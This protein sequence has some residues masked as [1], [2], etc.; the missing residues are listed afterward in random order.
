MNNRIIVTG[1]SGLV[2]RYL[3]D[4]MPDAIYLSS[5]DYDLINPIEVEQMFID[6]KPNIIIHLAAKVGGIFDNMNKPAEYFDENILMNTLIVKYSKKYNVD[7]L[8]AILSTCIYPDVV[9]NYP[10]V[11]SD[12]HIGPPAPT[13]FTYGY[14][15]RCLGVQIDAYNKQ[16]D[17]KYN[18]LIPSNLY[19]EYDNFGENSHYVA[20]LIKK[21]II[22]KQKGEKNIQLFGTGK[23][24][25]QF[26]YAGD[27]AKI[28]K[29]CIDD[30]IYENFNISTDNYTIKEIAEIA[31][32]AC[33]AEYLELLFDSTKPD[34]QY[35]KDV[36]N[37]KML[38]II[39]DFEPMTL[40]DGIKKTYDYLIKN[41]KI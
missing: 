29:R 30:N 24:L 10:M 6:L 1:G 7:R 40:F 16:Y 32:K 2:G 15:K 8:I 17:T 28:I 31:L 35:R 26:M 14:A 20:A 37:N 11:E 13:N 18:Y 38:N 5:K 33:D 22:A 21:I 4:I 41:N 39:D 12:L 19:G 34:G 3:K 9:D 25:R 36:S 23:P 27:F